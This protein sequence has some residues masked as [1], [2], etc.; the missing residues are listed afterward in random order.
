MNPAGSRRRRL[1]LFFA[2]LPLLLLAVVLVVRAQPRSRRLLLPPVNG[3]D[4]NEKHAVESLSRYL[5]VD[6]SVPPG[7]S[8]SA[9]SAYTQLLISRYAKPLH[10]DHHIIDRK[11]LLL[12]WRSGSDNSRPVLFLSHA[13]VV[14][15]APSELPKWTHPPFRGTVADGHLWG[16]GAIDNKAS[17]ICVLEA[18]AALQKANLKPR[19]D[20]HILVTPDEE[21]GGQT[22]AGRYVKEHIDTYGRPAFVIDEGSFIVPDIIPGLQL[23]A[24]AVGEKH[25]VTVRLHVTG[26]A[27]HASMPSPDDPPRV[28]AAALGRL[29]RFQY[30]IDVPAPVEA[31]LDRVS[32]VMPFHR[33]LVLKNRWLFGSLVHK[34]LTRKRTSNAILRSTW[35][36]TVIRSGVKDNVVPARAEAFLNLRL[37][38]GSDRDAAITLLRSYLGDARVKVDVET[39]WGDTPIAPWTGATWDRLEAA[40]NTALPGVVVV[41]SM[42]PGSMDARWFAQ[43]GIPAYRFQPF[44]LDAA[45]RKGIHGID[46]RISIANVRQAVRVY[47]ILIR[48][49]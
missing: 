2:P 6:T 25:Y 15:V 41:P 44:T 32:D 38:P 42:T 26:T 9:A 19:R 45:G 31:F 37:L 21:I 10:L 40:L 22:G 47:A 16:R 34:Q 23:A 18:I 39:D 43:A 30:P 24:V 3:L 17:T 7:I 14:P 13:D 11:T 12:R 4:I 48:H 29:N 1:L 36:L 28:L 33:R 8:D 27:G 49:L 5:Q 20:I 35:A 46:E